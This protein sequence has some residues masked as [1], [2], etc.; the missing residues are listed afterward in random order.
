[1]HH[2]RI[3]VRGTPRMLRVWDPRTLDLLRYLFA[4]ASMQ[5]LCL[6]ESSW[7]WLGR[8][9]DIRQLP[10]SP[11]HDW[12]DS[13]LP[14]SD[15]QI[16]V[17]LLAEAFNSTLN[18]LQDMR[19]DVVDGATLRKI[20]NALCRARSHWGIVDPLDQVRFALHACLIHDSFDTDEQVANA[21]RH[22][23]ALVGSPVQ[24]L[25]SFDEKAWEVVRERL[26]SDH[27]NT[28]LFIQE[29]VNHG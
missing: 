1:M 12:H 19:A 5:T 21:M 29:E 18:V 4:G 28:R 24:G 26:S 16:D 15:G 25:S 14:F 3:Y 10:E 23:G 22:S 8:D 9:G 17:L 11:A 2:S 13:R 27:S 6:P 20:V 7:Y